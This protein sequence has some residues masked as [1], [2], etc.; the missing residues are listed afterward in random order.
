MNV[1]LYKLG[2]DDVLRR[3]ALEHERDAIIE[4]AHVGLA[5]GHFHCRYHCKENFT[6]RT[7]VAQIA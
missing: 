4:E 2:L 7:L 6:G 5:G 3:C 1:Y